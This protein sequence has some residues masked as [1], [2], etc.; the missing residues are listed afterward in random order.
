MFKYSGDAYPGINGTC[1]NTLASLEEC[2]LEIEFSPLED[3]E[4]TEYLEI[5]FNTNSYETVDKI[6]LKGKGVDAGAKALLTI[7]ADSSLDF[8]TTN[9]GATSS[10][11]VFT[12]K[13]TGWGEAVLL[14]SDT[15]VLMDEEFKFSD[16]IYP[17]TNGT[18]SNKLASGATCKIEAVFIPSE[19]GEITGRINVVYN[20]GK[21]PE[22]R[23]LEVTGTGQI[24]T[25]RIYLGGDFISYNSVYQSLVRINTDGS[26]DT[27]FETGLGV[28]YGNFGGNIKSIL[29]QAD[30]K[31]IITGMV[32][33]Y[34]AISSS[35]VAR[36]NTDGSIDDLFT[37]GTGSDGDVM[38]SALQNDGKIIIAGSFTSYD[39]TARKNI[40]RLNSDGAL[41]TGFVVGSGFNNL[42][43]AVKIQSDGKL[44]VVGQFTSYAGTSINRIVRLN[45]DGSIDSSFD[46][47]VGADGIVWSLALDSSDKVYIG[48]DFTS[49]KGTSVNR[50]VRLN[51]D[52]SIDGAFNV[53][54]GFN[55]TVKAIGID[56][57]GKIVVA[58]SFSNYN[59]SA[60]NYLIRLNTDG[61]ID[62][63]LTPCFIDSYIHS[64]Y[65]Q[66]DGKII[67]S[68]DFI[69]PGISIARLNSDGSIDS[70]FDFGTGIKNVIQKLAIAIDSNSKVYIGGAFNTYNVDVK[71]KVVAIDFDSNIDPSFSTVSNINHQINTSALQAD[72]KLLIGTFCVSQY[73]LF[74]TNPWCAKGIAR[75]NTDGTIDESFN[76][77]TGFNGVVWSILLQDDGK[78]IAAGGFTAYN[79]DT[80]K[81][82]ARLNTDG[83]LDTSFDPGLGAGPNYMLDIVFSASL[84]SDGKIIVA[85]SFQTFDGVNRNRIARI[86]SD[87]SLDNTFDVGIG[88]SG[89]SNS[90]WAT[91]V[92]DDKVYIGGAFTSYN[93]TARNNIVR[94]NIDGTID[95]GFVVGTGFDSRVERIRIKDDIILVLGDFNQYNGTGRSK[96]ARLNADGSINT[97][98]VTSCA[99]NATIYDAFIQADGKIIIAGSFTNYCGV[100]RNRIARIGSNGVLDTTFSAGVHD[101][102]DYMVRTISAF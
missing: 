38:C 23:Y 40:A 20:N 55:T 25:D 9:V 41:D 82:I 92:K 68:G 33:T 8:G 79:G 10:S 19:V 35:G 93:G 101:G 44:I 32:Q 96:L 91:A 67:I 69:N 84:Q 63:T 7:T 39:G 65:V 97:G 81:S 95:P 98:L 26:H 4:Y 29:I 24:I 21:G 86:N 2:L 94:L 60:N 61:T 11:L 53:G 56:L 3:K 45:I 34:N 90:V 102:F 1:T 15:Q 27:S 22:T 49:Y 85:G 30:G 74:Y 62:N 99:A 54:T 5:L 51:S 14:G 88:T 18:C 70:S 17:G 12:V 78:I 37:P 16:N 73:N 100:P 47:G 75:L 77:G 57:N 46:V 52:G 66:A 87:G 36:L 64:L 72:G 42:V 48:G 13:N 50:I 89:G 83:T 59:G 28:R 43:E 31:I 6:L 71:H 58:G 80:V 76:M